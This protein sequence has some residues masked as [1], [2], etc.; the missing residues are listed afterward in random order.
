MAPRIGIIGGTG[1]YDPKM[2]K[3]KDK[4]T[5]S[6]PYGAPSDALQVGELDGVEVA[7]LPRHGS[8]HVYPPHKVNY[9]ANIWAMKQLGVERIISPCAVGSLKED[10]KPGELVIV[11]QFIDFTKG[12]D[13]TFYDGAKTVHISLADPFCPELNSLFAKEAKRLK[14]PHHVGGTYVCIEGP[15]FSTRAESRMYRQ[16]AD[17]IGMTLV[18][19]CQL[20]RELDMCYTSLATVTDYDVWA[21]EPVDISIV[22]KVMAENVEKVRKLISA[23]LPKIPAARKKCPCPNTLKEAGL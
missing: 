16:F 2:F 10:I 12:R 19:E 13:Y 17:I 21:E 18:P 15:R 5:L 11:D 20:A 8:G 1:V 6:T 3:I 22:L 14:I 7:F 23:T 4:I 9:R